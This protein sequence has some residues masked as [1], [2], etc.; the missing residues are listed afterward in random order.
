MEFDIE[1]LSKVTEESGAADDFKKTEALTKDI[2]NLQGEISQLDDPEKKAELQEKIIQLTQEQETR[3]NDAVNKLSQKLTAKEIPKENT[4]RVMDIIKKFMADTGGNIPDPGSA[5]FQKF[6]GDIRYASA[7]TADALEKIGN[8]FK[9]V[10]DKASPEVKADAQKYLDGQIKSMTEG[11]KNYYKDITKTEIFTE[12]NAS[13][14]FTAL[15]WLITISMVAGGIYGVVYAIKKQQNE[16][17]G[18][19]L[20]DQKISTNNTCAGCTAGDACAKNPETGKLTCGMN[21]AYGSMKECK[22][23]T[24]VCTCKTFSFGDELAKGFNHIG[25]FFKQ[26]FDVIGTLLDGL[27]DLLKGLANAGPY[28]MIVVVVIIVFIGLKF[29]LS[30]GE[31]AL[32]PKKSE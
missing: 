21:T 4:K 30:A 20:N 13:R 3:V 15:K 25:D 5:Q 27:N 24:D 23:I 29:V 19:Y 2:S 28:L 31:S 9:E 26:G 8:V 17:S 14:F 7:D 6:V 18:C 11:M 1:E 10:S 16:D 12:K 22:S 32:G